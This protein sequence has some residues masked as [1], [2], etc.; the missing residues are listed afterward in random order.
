MSPSNRYQD[1]TPYPQVG[2][3]STQKKSIRKDM[4]NRSIC[5]KSLNRGK[6][7]TGLKTELSMTKTEK[8][9][10]V[11]KRESNESR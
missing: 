6:E 9:L 2:R 10:I 4:Q 11:V 5:S 8:N 3:S 7:K 1:T